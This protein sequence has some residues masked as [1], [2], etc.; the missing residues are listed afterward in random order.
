VLGNFTDTKN[1]LLEANLKFQMVNFLYEILD[2]IA[3]EKSRKPVF[4]ITILLTYSS[5]A[6]PAW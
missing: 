3:A 2:T 4:S 6:Q 1:K 5:G